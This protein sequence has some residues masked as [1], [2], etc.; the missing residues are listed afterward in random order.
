MEQA[1]FERK[2]GKLGS[3]VTYIDLDRQQKP[4]EPTTAGW[5]DEQIRAKPLGE[6]DA[7]ISSGQLGVDQLRTTIITEEQRIADL[8]RV[9]N[10]KIDLN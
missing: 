8:H 1:E 6:I 9:R 2:H 3:D 5:T 7:M 4:P 10:R